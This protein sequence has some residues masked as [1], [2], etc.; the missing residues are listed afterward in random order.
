[1]SRHNL[2]RQPPR[3]SRRGAG[4]RG[5][6]RLGALFALLVGINIYVFFFRGGSSVGELLR[7]GAIQKAKP[8]AHQ[9]ERRAAKKVSATSSLPLAGLTEHASTPAR[10]IVRGSLKGQAGLAKALA[11]TK[12]DAPQISALIKALRTQLNLRSLRPEHT[13][14]IELDA[15][16][17]SQLRRFT[18]NLSP[19]KRVVVVRRRDGSLRAREVE[20]KLRIVRRHVGARVDSSLEQAIQDAGESPTLLYRLLR[21]F[22]WD[23]NW[24]TDVRKGDTFRVLVEKKYLGDK[25][26][27]YGRLLAAEYKGKKTGRVQ[28]IYFRRRNGDEGHYTP[29]GRS[30]RRPLIK[31]PINYRRISSRFNHNRF[32]PVLHR[33]KAHLGI[34]YAAP[35]GTPIYAAGDGVVT[36]RKRSGPA[37]HMI[38]IRHPSGLVSV[39][40]HLSRYARGLRVG[41]TVKQWKVIGYVG[42]TGRSTGPH[43]HFGLKVGGRYVDPMGYP[44]P[45]GA[46]LGRGE[47]ARFMSGLGKR[48]ADLDRIKVWT[49]SAGARGKGATSAPEAP[50]TAD[51]DDLWS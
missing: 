44:I 38:Q 8:A 22:S 51:D 34:D 2:L 21:L 35:T 17:P 6:L 23:I 20:S 7:T 43:L 24:S 28:A 27:S 50:A 26:Y 39:Y 3:G 1:M 36:W 18:Y 19:I 41:Q 4:L 13:F 42:T 30:I 31:T 25:L 5:S 29:E 48:L 46:M 16:P 45:R 32:H 15:T 37:G 14:E 10:Q 9:K 11:A 47:R 40:M 33:V 12:L 49:K